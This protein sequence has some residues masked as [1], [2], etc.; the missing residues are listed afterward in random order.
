MPMNREERAK[1]FAP[2]ESMHGLREALAKKEREHEMQERITLSEE[3]EADIAA[4]LSEL[5]AGD[6]IDMVCFVDGFYVKVRG[7]V[8]KIDFSFRILQVENG[9]V[10]FSDLFSL[11]IFHKCDFSENF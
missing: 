1:Q 9:K 2:F 5:K 10:P 8:R 11:E 4:T 3:Q 7:K 6:L